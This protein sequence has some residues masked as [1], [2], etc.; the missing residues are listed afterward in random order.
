MQ[1][2]RL[3]HGHLAVESPCGGARQLLIAQAA[4]SASLPLFASDQP[5]LVSHRRLMA[6]CRFRK[7][8]LTVS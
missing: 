5:N 4:E 7:L 6:V 1:L 2:D 8:L 3:L